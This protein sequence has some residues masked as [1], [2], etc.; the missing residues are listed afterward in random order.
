MMPQFLVLIAQFEQSPTRAL[1]E[2]LKSW[3]EPIVRM[4]RSTKSSG[5]TE[6]FHT[7]MEMP[8]R[9]AYGFRSFEHYRMRVLALCSWSGVINRV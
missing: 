7:K 5:L 8:S 1:A 4:W 3:L 6:G 9:R 2:M